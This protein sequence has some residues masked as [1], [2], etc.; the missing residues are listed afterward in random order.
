MDEKDDNSRIPEDF[1]SQTNTNSLKLM[2]D[3]LKHAGGNPLVALGSILVCAGRAISFSTIKLSVAINLILAQYETMQEM[4]SAD[5]SDEIKLP[6]GSTW[7]K[8]SN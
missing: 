8:D 6:D 1:A 5:D 7:P 2:A 3:A 4:R